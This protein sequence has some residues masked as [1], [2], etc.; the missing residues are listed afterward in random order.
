MTFIN[1]YITMINNIKCN[2]N[3]LNK[4]IKKF[5][6][7]SDSSI[8]TNIDIEIQEIIK[9]NI[10]DSNLY[11]KKDILIISEED[12]LDYYDYNE[13]LKKYDDIITIDPLDGTENFYSGLNYWGV[14]YSH[15]TKD[16]IENIFKHF[17]SFILLPQLNVYID[18]I[19]TID[20]NK[21]ESRIIGLS[22]YL[23][24]KEIESNTKDKHEEYRII[25]S[26]VCN[27][28]NTIKGIFKE[29][30]NPRINSWDILAGI[31]IALLNKL[32]VKINGEKYEGQ[33]LL[34]NEKYN[35]EISK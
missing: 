23:N 29:Y 14:S 7:K 19:N 31:N 21:F 4:G 17:F 30:K 15:Y 5:N 13:L 2:I 1:N 9:K 3:V 20:K 16:H 11:N 18:S 32:K 34:P 27:L 12:K 35:L 8:V 24:L 10:I 28:Y 25:G 33:L 26:A 6:I 22:S